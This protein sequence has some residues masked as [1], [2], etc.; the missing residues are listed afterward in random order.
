M[1]FIETELK[2]AYII[3]IEKIEDERGFFARAF[4]KNEFVNYGLESEFVQHNVSF[5]KKAGTL[6]GMHLQLAPSGEA[7]VVS[8]IKGAI[9]DVI[10]DLR[11]QSPTFMKW[12]SIELHGDSGRMLYIPKDFA[13]GFQTLEDETAVY[14][15]MSE[16][17]KPDSAFTINFNDPLFS[18]KWPVKNITVSSK[19][20]QAAFIKEF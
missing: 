3:D 11:R 2:G 12:I 10:I 5:N 16:F 1:K 15:W 8:C 4:C 14:Y 13:H 18:I 20:S 9:Y 17:Y 19:D 6:R 7:K